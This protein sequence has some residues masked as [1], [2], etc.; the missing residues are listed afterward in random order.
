MTGRTEGGAT[1]R[2]EGGEGGGGGAW[3]EREQGLEARRAQG[4]AKGLVHLGDAYMKLEQVRAG[5]GK[6][7]QNMIL[8]PIN[9]VRRLLGSIPVSYNV[10]AS[11]I[12]TSEH[13]GVMWYLF[14][15]IRPETCTSSS[16]HSP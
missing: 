16:C 6:A 7:K 3:G 12:S 1:G 2:R 8:V 10:S 5:G 11:E 4:I 14:F 13:E 9:A 15:D